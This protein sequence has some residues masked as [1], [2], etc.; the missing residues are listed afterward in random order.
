MKAASYNLPH[1]IV[2]K[3]THERGEGYTPWAFFLLLAP[4]CCLNPTPEVA[5]YSEM[6]QK[7]RL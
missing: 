1:M 3:I 2:Q 6:S 5:K 4:I 7:C